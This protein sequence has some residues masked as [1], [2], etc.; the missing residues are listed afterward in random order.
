MTL[1]GCPVYELH[2][3]FRKLETNLQENHFCCQESN[4][5]I[6][7]PLLIFGVELHTVTHGD[8]S[9]RYL[10]L[11]FYHEGKTVLLPGTPLRN[12]YPN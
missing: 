10:Q 3:V 9:L 8:K 4:L 11:L 12:A 7:V 5:Y 6:D 2:E 1:W